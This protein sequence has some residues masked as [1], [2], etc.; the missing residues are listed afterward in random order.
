MPPFRGE[1]VSI[2][3]LTTEPQI[4]PFSLPNVRWFIAFRLLFNSRFYYPVFAII[5]LDFGLSVEQFALLNVVWAAAIVCLEVP[6]G[7]LA[8]LIGRR[9]LVVAAGFF[10][11]VEFALIAFVPLGNIGLVFA[12]FVLNRI[13]SGAAEAAASGA[14]EALAYDTVQQAGLEKQWPRVLDIL[15]RCQS[16][17]FLVAMILGAA[18]YDPV[19]MQRFFDSLGISFTL[20]QQITMRFPLY[21]TLITGFLAFLAAL[22]LQEVSTEQ[23]ENPRE[24]SIRGTFAQTLKAGGW[25]LRTPFALMVILAVISVDSVSRLFATLM[26]NYFR[27]IG[28]PEA[29]FGLISAAMFMMGFFTPPVARWLSERKSPLF[30]FGLMAALLLAGLFGIAHTSTFAGLFFS[31]IIFM[32]MSLLGFFSS[33]YLNAI[34]E[35]SQRATVLSFRGLAINLAY[36]SIGLFYAGLMRYLDFQGDPHP[37]AASLGWFP[38][39]FVGV[40]IALLIAGRIILRKTDRHLK[41]C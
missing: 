16:V 10:M 40:L 32:I 13:L 18:I 1:L 39:F 24:V 17:G 11:I 26:S 21:L 9:R 35:S 31:A 4:S 22:R 36:G 23:P 5:F 27:L 34:T 33:Q 29:S 19:L 12:V 15:M 25:I 6:S 30:N 28:L 41:P 8:D 2:G 3:P 7:A 37:F 14:D 38:W 20:N